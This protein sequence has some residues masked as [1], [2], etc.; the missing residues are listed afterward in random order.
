MH[1]DFVMLYR[2]M[3]LEGIHT[4]A[5]VITGGS[6]GIGRDVALAFA[7]PGK[8]IVIN[9]NSDGAS[10]EA[11][12]REVR[13][14]GARTLV[15]QADAGTVEGCQKIADAVRNDGA[16]VEMA[17]H[18]AVDA[19]AVPVL[20]S[21]PARMARAVETNSLSILYLV[22][23]LDE[24]LDRGSTIF[25]FTSRG[26]RIVVKNYA[27]IGVGKAATEA[28][29][30]Y[31]ATELAPR[32]IRINSIAPSIVGTEAVRHIFGEDETRS[33]M[34]HARDSNP[35][36]RAVEPRD[37]TEIIRFLASPAAEF[38]TGQVVFVNGGA[39]LSA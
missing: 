24:L 3:I 10:A 11:T 21:D 38:I 9:F 29:I 30:R 27:A 12:A 4:M 15:V 19:Y 37:Y 28:L 1:Y 14:R 16:R 26:G 2:T 8:T 5:I 7:E 23:T 33:L 20:Q 25:F 18:C 39:N 22:Q 6:K 31:M 17:V 13:D 32:G 36:G 34:D 35:S